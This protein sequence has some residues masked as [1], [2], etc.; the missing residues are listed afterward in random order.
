MPATHS[1]DDQWHGAVKVEFESNSMSSVVRRRDGLPS[2]QIAST[3]DDVDYEI[4][5][6]IRGA[7]LLE[8][9]AF[10]HYLS[11]ICG[12]P[13][14]RKINFMHHPLVTADGS[15]LSKSAGATSLKH[16][17]DS[18]VRADQF[19]LWMSRSLGVAH[20]TNATELLELVPDVLIPSSE[21]LG[22][23]KG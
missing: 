12:L 16:L 11:D 1:F 3:V 2:Y 19:Y 18:G 6:I 5:D 13:A 23:T 9:S 10:Q 22:W 8:S 14:F 20:A 17:R 15:K 4:T 7:D 21:N